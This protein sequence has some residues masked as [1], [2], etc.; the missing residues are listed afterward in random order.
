MKTNE[1]FRESV[2]NVAP[3][4]RRLVDISFR[5]A[6]RIDGALKEKNLTQRDFA[7][8]LNKKESE[9]SRWLTGR[10]NFTLSTIAKIECVLGV[11]LI[12]AT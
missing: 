1:L 11:Q 4:T 3:E 8:L 9:V 2:A 6:E 7:K 5:L 10:H 12:D